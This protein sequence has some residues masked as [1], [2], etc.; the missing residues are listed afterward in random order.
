MEE[1]RILQVKDIA[2]QGGLGFWLAGHPL[3][4]RSGRLQM[5]EV[6]GFRRYYA[7]IRTAALAAANEGSRHWTTTWPLCE[8]VMLGLTVYRH[9]TAEQVP[10]LSNYVKAVEDALTGM[11]VDDD[12]RIVGYLPGTGKVQGV[13]EGIS[14]ILV[15][16]RT[17]HL[18][19][20]KKFRPI[21]IQGREHPA[22][23]GR[24]A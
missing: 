13:W 7:D 23:G 3:A 6:R 24:G 8:A 11:A 15:P 17:M 22:V 21:S 4:R 20:Y 5:Q 10:D 19:S 2:R 18:I 1:P 9:E 16:A 14:V 12:R